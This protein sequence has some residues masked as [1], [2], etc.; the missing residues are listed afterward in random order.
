MK[1]PKENEYDNVEYKLHIRECSSFKIEKY[2][3][4]MNY[5]LYN[6]KGV[7]FYLIGIQ[8]NGNIIGMNYNALYKSILNLLRICGRIGAHHQKILIIKVSKKYFGLVKII[9]DVKNYTFSD[10][11]SFNTP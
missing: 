5:R 3:T 10:F 2:A 7:A 11:I 9:G 4:Q 8:D 1:F 6:G